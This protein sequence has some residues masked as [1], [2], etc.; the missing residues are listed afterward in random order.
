MRLV[1]A[2]VALAVPLAAQDTRPVGRQPDGSVRTSTEQII[3]P[4]GRTVEFPGRP[5]DLVLIDQDRVAVVKNRTDLVFL[6]LAD[7]TVLQTLPAPRNGMSYHGIAATPDGGRV[8]VTGSHD[9]LWVAVRERGVARFAEP[10]RLPGPGGKG[11]SAPG[12]IALDGNLLYVALSRNN[13]LGV[14]DLAQGKLVREI[15]VGVAP[16]GVVLDGKLAYVSN[17]GG[18]HPRPGE[19]SDPSSGTPTLVDERTNASASGT[20]SVVDLEQGREARQIEVGLHPCGMVLDG[21]RRLLFVAN[22]NSDTVSAIDLGTLRVARTIPV[23]PRP[24]L[25]FG[26][27]PNAVALAA[28]GARL[29]VALGTNNAVAAVDPEAGTLLGLLP[30]GWYPGALAVTRRAGWLVVANVKGVGSLHPPTDRIGFNSHNHLGSV[31]ILTDL[32]A[33]TLRD[34]AAAVARQNRH[35]ALDLYL[36]PPR[37]GVAARPVPERHGEPSVFEHVV[38]ILRENRTYDQVLGDLQQGNGDASLCIYGRNVTPNTHALAEEFVL[39]DNFYCS[40]VLSADGHA[41]ATEAYVTDYLEKSFG[42]FVRS[43][44]YDGDDP[45]AYASTGFLWDNALARGRTFRSY[46]EMVQAKIEPSGTW[47]QL[48]DD[49]QRGT[50]RHRITARSHLDAV[51]ANMCPT[52]VGFPDEV[53]DQYRADEFLK[54]LRRFEQEGGF[55]N[56][57]V[58]LL[59]NDHTAGTRPGMP[60]PEA[61][62]A[63]ND[64][65]LGR[66]V[67]AISR[68]RFWPKTCILVVQD[69]PQGG[70]DHVD[71]HRTVALAISPYTRRKAVVSQHYNQIGMVKTIEL[72]L[73]LPPMNQFDLLATPMTECFQA[74]PDL[75]PYTARKNQIALDT[76]NASL[77]RLRG[78]A[79]RDAVASILMESD[80]VDTA[81]EDTLNRILWHAAKGHATPYPARFAA[82]QRPR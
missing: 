26:S 59:P 45:L 9:A 57:V 80:E 41:W 18:R 63:D 69:D 16:F 48:W 31:T 62:V 56:L 72:I 43:Y 66:V 39:L 81:D 10:I 25:P 52:F 8:Y 65:A 77:W 5:T 42:G 30:V 33:E 23:R 78:P 19:P 71:G 17:R 34:G 12:G 21:K 15:P 55:P 22:A 13:S 68:S 35:S 49:Y 28:D 64:L 58:M 1:L 29:F 67:E 53:S 74:E 11:E 70:W 37:P 4:F 61:M 2:T 7:R 54:E 60:R 6:R 79:L 76:M 36:Q 27:T 82:V 73:G 47:Q 75:T 24:D 38:Y 50:G 44:P 14:V 46:G 3:Q 40:G 20:V 32:R 51:R